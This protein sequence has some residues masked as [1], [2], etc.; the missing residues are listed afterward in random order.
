LAAYI[1]VVENFLNPYANN[2]EYD[3]VNLNAE[4]EVSNGQILCYASCI[5]QVKTI[6]IVPVNKNYSYPTSIQILLE[7]GP[8]GSK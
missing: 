5:F 8:V 3:G 7:R 6:P 4:F 1:R 2:L